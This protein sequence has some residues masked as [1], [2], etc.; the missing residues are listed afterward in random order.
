MIYV[1]SDLHGI[2]LDTF[3]ALL[4]SVKFSKDDY[5]FILGD[6]IDRG[7]SGIE[8]LKYLTDKENIELILGNHEAMM[9]GCKFIF[10]KVTE[11]S[12]DSLTKEKLAIL[13]AWMRNG[14][15]PTM[16]AL[17]HETDAG[18]DEIYE[19]LLDCPLYDTVSV[20][21]KDFLLTHSG[22]GN[23][24]KNKRI[25]DYTQSELL[26]ERP[27]IS[28][29]YFDSVITVFGHTPTKHY[30]EKYNGKILKTATWIDI[31]VGVVYG[32]APAILRLDDLSEFYLDK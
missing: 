3:K 23:F 26:W 31:D 15:E 21:G 13:Q 18:V 14:A 4:D 16:N 7:Q 5:L 17:K 22:L 20:N 30:G 6:V 29:R 27:K 9:L 24:E 2:S 32:N 10:D 19:Y 1:T 25:K 8:L 12:I 28:D 11:Q